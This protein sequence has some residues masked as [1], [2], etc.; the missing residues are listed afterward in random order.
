MMKA[1][2]NPTLNHLLT[3]RPIPEA[4]TRNI[5]NDFQ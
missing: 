2:Q 1:S 5:K 4:T 3:K